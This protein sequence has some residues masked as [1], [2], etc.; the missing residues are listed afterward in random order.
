MRTLHAACAVTSVQAHTGRASLKFQALLPILSVRKLIDEK[1]FQEDGGP[2]ADFSAAAQSNRNPDSPRTTVF[3]DSCGQAAR[4]HALASPPDSENEPVPRAAPATA[5]SAPNHG[6]SDP[7]IRVWVSR[8]NSLRDCKGSA[9]RRKR[10][11]RQYP[12]QSRSERFVTRRAG[13]KRR[14]REAP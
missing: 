1:G 10:S 11:F 12:A 4:S 2:F 6:S 3:K 8:S 7:R 14:R 5:P 9:G 13:A